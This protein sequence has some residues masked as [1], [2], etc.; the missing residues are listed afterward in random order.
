[1]TADPIETR[2]RFLL[3]LTQSPI[4]AM[5]SLRGRPHGCSPSLV[6]CGVGPDSA[7]SFRY[8]CEMEIDEPH[9]K[10]AYGIDQDGNR[11]RV[12]FRKGG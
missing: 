10:C 5:D 8:I 3:L 6:N 2:T 7:N 4:D 11:G 1:M 12:K 9:E